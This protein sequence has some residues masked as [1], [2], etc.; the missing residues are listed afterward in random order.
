MFHI[1]QVPSLEQVANFLVSLA[2]LR[3]FTE[4]CEAHTGRRKVVGGDIDAFTT[5]TSLLRR[6]GT[7]SH[8]R[9]NVPSDR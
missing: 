5:G 3:S 4:L 9:D 2:K 8:Y 6:W 7:M 1:F